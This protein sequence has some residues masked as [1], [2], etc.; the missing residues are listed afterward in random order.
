[1]K[2]YQLKVD[3]YSSHQLIKQVICRRFPNSAQILDLGCDT[4]FLGEL[5]ND[6]PND[7]YLEGVDKDKKKLS[8]AKKYYNHTYSFDLNRRHWPLKKHYD[9]VVIADTLEHLVEPSHVLRNVL[10]LLKPTAIAIISVPNS[11]HWWARLMIALGKF[12]QQSRGLFD[13]THLHYFTLDTVTSLIK[14]GPEIEMVDLLQTTFPLQFVLGKW[15]RL[16]I[17]KAFYYISFILAQLKPSL[18]A[19]QHI[20]IIRKR[21]SVKIS[22]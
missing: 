16:W 2:N 6:L 20:F 12:P 15:N 22:M 21:N 11:V 10:L 18:F 8:V 19:Y 1:M 7:Y 17:S 5:I 4:G 13:R 9:V 14:S 3:E